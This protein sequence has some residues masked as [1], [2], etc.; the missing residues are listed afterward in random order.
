[1]IPVDR[2]HVLNPRSRNKR[3]HREITE[4]IGKIGLKRPITVSRRASAD[5]ASSYDLVC[6]QGRLEA[7]QVLGHKDIPAFVVAAEEESCLI[8]SLVE[9][10]AR[11]Q[12]RAIE[13]MQEIG[14]LK[15]RGYND[16]QVA[17]KLGVTASWVAMVTG[18][19]D[20]GEERLVAAVETG[21][22][23]VSL[24]VD[25]ARSDDAGVQEALAEAYTQG[26]LK[27][28]KLAVVRRILQQRAL[29][30]KKTEV[31]SRERPKTS[32]KVTAADLQRV[33]EKEVQKQQLLAKKAEFTQGRLLFVIEA[34]RVLKNDKNFVELLRAEG[35]DSMP[36]A[37]EDRLT[38]RA[39]Q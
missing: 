15:K 31:R 14:A 23:P 39:I 12:Y 18:L 32:R 30:K 28:K 21:I 1:M 29:R 36:R 34:L 8:M 26:N 3:L 37:L 10:I 7:F 16:E 24:A 25:I 35:V 11:R 22:I 9:N 17:D 13:L 2:I 33:Y 20:R 4:N 5:G 19:L 6:G 27:G 38:R